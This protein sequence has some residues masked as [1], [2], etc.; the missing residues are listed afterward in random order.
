MLF[1]LQG[2]AAETITT[3]LSQVKA[4]LA[5]VALINDDCWAFT[6]RGAGANG[7]DFVSS[8]DPRRGSDN[9]WQL[10]QSFGD[11][12]E[13]TRQEKFRH[14]RM[15]DEQA[16]ISE[17]IDWQSVVF[18]EQQ[19]GEL[20][21]GFVPVARDDEERSL[22]E[23]LQGRVVIDAAS[24]QLIRIQWLAKRPFQPRFGIKIT[25]FYLNVDYQQIG[26]LLFP[27]QTS[28]EIKGVAL[29]VKKIDKSITTQH[30][31][32]VNTCVDSDQGS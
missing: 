2:F 30:Q 7:E 31:K 27:D 19:G 1:Q 28:I 23:H 14:S 18:I 24:G 11:E 21:Y 26:H 4:A 16:L 13:Q 3:G 29:M 32:F 12:P 5:R 10:T 8:R 6:M 9:L 22:V 17:A 15:R 20:S 25:D